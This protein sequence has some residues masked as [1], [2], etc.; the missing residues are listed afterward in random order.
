MKIF[1]IPVAW[2][3]S[4]FI[5]SAMAAIHATPWVALEGGVDFAMHSTH[6]NVVSMPGVDLPDNYLFN[7]LQNNWMLGIGAGYQFTRPQTL[8]PS[9]SAQWLPSDRLGFF[10]DYYAPQQLSGVIN[11]YMIDTAYTD[12]VTVHSN[13]LWLDNQLDITHIR[14]FTPF[15]DLGLGVSRNTA[16]GYAETPT[17]D[18]LSPRADSAAFATHNNLA[19]AYRAG[20]GVN[21]HLATTWPV[22]VGIMYRYT[23]R[24]RV[25]TG[26]SANYSI[27]AL[28]SN[29]L[30][31]NEISLVF[32]SYF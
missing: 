2:I 31:S 21:Y 23:D 16:A 15:I 32:R 29:H 5:S 7:H 26:D 25:K 10:Y 20:F 4:L 6:S 1:F 8:L 13:T 17:A 9:L 12:H 28:S 27:G 30:T 11:K 22:D 24:G 3:S 19:L 18:N 14:A